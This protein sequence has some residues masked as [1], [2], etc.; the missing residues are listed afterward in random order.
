LCLAQV[1]LVYHRPIDTAWEE[2]AKGL[3]TYL[4]QVT[5]YLE[6]PATSSTCSADL[7]LCAAAVACRK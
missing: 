5:D 1:T 6:V 7:T 4:A 3:R 2:A